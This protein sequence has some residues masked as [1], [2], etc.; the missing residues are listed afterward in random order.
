MKIH[1]GFCALLAVV[2]TAVFAL[3]QADPPGVIWGEK[4]EVAAGGGYRGPWRMNESEYD[5]VDDPTVAINEQGFVAVAWA[6]QSRKDIFVQVYAPD[7]RQRLEEPVNIS[8]SPRVFSWL[9][10]MLITSTDPIEVYL[11]W[12]E[13]VF[14]GGS[15]GGDIFFARSTDGGKTFS[16]PLNLS[17]DIAGSGKGRLT[18]RYW[19]NGSLDLAIGPEGHLY[20]AWT[21][22][23]GTLWVSRSTDRGGRFSRPL[24]VAGWGDAK[25]ARGPSLAVDAPG[26]VYL[27]WTVG[28]DRAASIRVARSTDRARSFGQPRVVESDGHSDAPKIATDGKGTV[29][30]VYAESPAG[31]FERYRI[32]YTRSLDR[33]RTFAAPKEL[34]SLHTE[35]FASV[36]FPALSVDGRDNLYVLW[37]LFPSR[38]TYSQGLGFTSSRDA[39]RTFAPPMVIPGSVDPALGFNGSQQGLFMRKLAVNGAG[40]IAVVNST[41]KPNEKSRV[42]LFRG[43]AAGR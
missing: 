2:P 22:Y 24:R 29:H 5:Y 42:R 10:R 32:R 34:S 6:D 38:G 9:P 17:N 27:A 15:H 16:N 35:K 30:V 25:P 21:E 41:F 43:Q 7:R 8:R 40:A 33:G 12:Q 20:A 19:H 4:I 31:P 18:R 23:E 28:E 37:E 36:N 11:L 13:I 3:G 39:G 26:D 14:S 1:L